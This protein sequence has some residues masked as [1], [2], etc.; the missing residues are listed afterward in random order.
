MVKKSKSM[1][2]GE[3]KNSF[4]PSDSVYVLMKNRQTRLV[5]PS[6]TWSDHCLEQCKFKLF[7]NGK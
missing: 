2:E 7:W 6:Q 5:L 4:N 1:M 3:G